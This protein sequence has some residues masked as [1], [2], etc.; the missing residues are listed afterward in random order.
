LERGHVPD[1]GT[2]ALTLTTCFDLLAGYHCAVKEVCMLCKGS[3][4]NGLCT[5]PAA[6]QHAADT[7]HG[8]E[9]QLLVM[10]CPPSNPVTPLQ[11]VV[12]QPTR[13]LH[14][15]STGCAAAVNSRP[16][17]SSATLVVCRC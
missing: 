17:C 12:V 1:A 13:G 10:P 8:F 9:Q 7:G 14:V 15:C 5:F 2:G 11:L 16:S 6:T 3:A 4:E